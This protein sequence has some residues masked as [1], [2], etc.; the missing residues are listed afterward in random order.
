MADLDININVKLVKSVYYYLV[1]ALPAFTIK[2]FPQPI[3][4]FL[5][6]KTLITIYVNGIMEEKY[7]FN[8]V[9]NHLIKE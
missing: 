5:R 1:L 6:R 4:W 3:I 8:K 7:T 2:K 9:L